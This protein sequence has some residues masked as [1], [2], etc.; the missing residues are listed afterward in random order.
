MQFQ[1]SDDSEDEQAKE[2]ERKA[3][4]EKNQKDSMASSKGGNTPSG[5][6]KHADPLKKG[7]AT[8]TRKRLGSP[9]VS[10]A[11]GTDTS[12]KKGKSKHASSQPTPQPSS[13]PMSPMASSATHVSIEA[14]NSWNKELMHP[15]G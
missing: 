15:L 2:E 10:D 8:A 14:T 12:R 4:E 9:N 3:E 6:P 11:S 5:R 7:S 13:R 1:T